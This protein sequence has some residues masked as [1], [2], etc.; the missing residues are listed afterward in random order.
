[1]VCCLSHA[2]DG[3]VFS[4]LGH[5]KNLQMQHCSIAAVGTAPL[6][7]LTGL[8]TLNLG[9]NMLTEEHLS[10]MGWGSG[11]NSLL[12]YISLASNQITTLP[13]GVF[14]NLTALTNLYVNKNDIVRDLQKEIT[15]LKEKLMSFE[16]K[17]LTARALTSL[18]ALHT[19]ELGAAV[20][21]ED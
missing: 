1:M 10:A 8:Q 14:A 12:Q 6:S 4:G 13:S 2:S 5:L 11:A 9:D 16:G 7:S 21:V 3:D 20:R 17:A 15:E 18:T 19:L